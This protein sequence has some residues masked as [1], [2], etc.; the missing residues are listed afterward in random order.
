MLQSLLWAQSLSWPAW[1]STDLA[2]F[3][4]SI[5]TSFE[6]RRCIPEAHHQ[7]DMPFPKLGSSSSPQ[8]AACCQEYACRHVLWLCWHGCTP[9]LSEARRAPSP[10]SPAA[11][12]THPS[13]GY[14]GRGGR[15]PWWGSQ[16]HEPR[17]QSYIGDADLTPCL[18]S[19]ALN[20]TLHA[21]VPGSPSLPPR[22]CVTTTTDSL[23]TPPE[24]REQAPACATSSL[25]LLEAVI[26]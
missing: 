26:R 23:S 19:W 16:P 2:S 7:P 21:A 15:R 1:V 14:Q 24:K 8:L 18:R 20:F 13:W 9:H 10:T 17:L 11:S 12:E 25:V 3:Y 22:F 4:I 5:V 6:F